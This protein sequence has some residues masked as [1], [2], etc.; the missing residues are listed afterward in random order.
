[1][2][3]RP[4]GTF[5]K[6]NSPLLQ[7]PK[8]QTEYTLSDSFSTALAFASKALHGVLPSEQQKEFVWPWLDAPARKIVMFRDDLFGNGD[9]D[10][11]QV[12]EHGDQNRLIKFICDN[13]FCICVYLKKRVMPLAHKGPWRVA[14]A[15]YYR[16]VDCP[17]DSQ[18]RWVNCSYIVVFEPLSVPTGFGPEH[19]T[20]SRFE[21]DQMP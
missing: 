21:Y 15:E 14:G 4:F 18:S 10:D 19:Y 1:M 12:D 2:R 7:P 8:K 20:E 17:P 6:K 11:D 13:D 5:G 16:R 3:D 9:N